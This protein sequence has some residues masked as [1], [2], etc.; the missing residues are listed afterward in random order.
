MLLLRRGG[1][2][3]VLRW[4]QRGL[5]TRRH[6]LDDRDYDLGR[7][8]KDAPLDL[9]NDFNTGHD[10]LL[11]ERYTLANTVKYC[12]LGFGRF[13]RLALLP[14]DHGSRW[15]GDVWRTGRNELLWGGGRHCGRGRQMWRSQ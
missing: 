9:P 10:L 5:W 4:R 12:L 6:G 7:L 11:V 8:G 14:R 15:W 13:V 3:I 2:S 1:R